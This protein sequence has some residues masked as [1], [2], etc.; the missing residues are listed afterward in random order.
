MARRLL[1]S[2][3]PNNGLVLLAA[4]LWLVWPAA[5]LAQTA[6]APGKSV[7]NAVANLVQ[8]RILISG[9]AAY[10]AVRVNVVSGQ[11]QG[12]P[13]NALQLA[14][15]AAPLF[16]LSGPD[17]PEDGADKRLF[18]PYRIAAGARCGGSGMNQQMMGTNFLLRKGQEFI[19]LSYLVAG[20]DMEKFSSTNSAYV[21][22]RLPDDELQKLRD[23]ARTIQA[24]IEARPYSAI[25]LRSKSGLLYAVPSSTRK[26]SQFEYGLGD[27]PDL[28][29]ISIKPNVNLGV[30]ADDFSV[31]LQSVWVVHCDYEGPHIELDNWKQALS[32]PKPL[33]RLPD[34]PADKLLGSLRFA[35][36]LSGI[37]P[38]RFPAYTETE[39]RRAIKAHWGEKGLASAAEAKPCAP[40]ERGHR[41][42]VRW[43]GQVVQEID[44]NQPLGC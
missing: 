28:S 22:A 18:Y 16:E 25:E 29:L 38:P 5:V 26:R 20:T 8:G 41:V 23:C 21:T 24:G 34:N 9:K 14:I 43:R 2:A 3:L 15:D 7:A 6:T 4:S 17:A 33:R 12:E 10:L 40:A 30:L 42:L 27:A 37:T 32:A 35:V 44:V 36:D 11:G 31:E 1:G 13:G 39:L 19:D